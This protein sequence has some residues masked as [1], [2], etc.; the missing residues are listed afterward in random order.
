[1]TA[2]DPVRAIADAVLYEGYILWPYRRSAMKNQRRWTFGGVYPRAHSATHPDDPWTMRTECLLE[3][4]P[5][6]TVEIRVRFL[7]VVARRV[8]RATGDGLALVDELTVGSERHV[9]WEEAVEREI[10]VGPAAVGSVAA[11]GR[12][13]AIDVRDGSEREDLCAPDST[14]A[15]ALIRS[16]HALAGAVEVSAE[17]LD[18]ALW[19]VSVTIANTT[20][21][22]RDDREQALERTFCSTHTVLRAGGGGAFVSLT[23]PP[24]AL[25]AHADACENTG[26]WPVLVGE[27]GATGTLLSSPI[28]LED[29]PR[30]APESP[31]DLCDGGEIDQLL[32]LNILSLTD[33]EKAEM[34]AT[35][36]RGREILERAEALTP[37]EIM[38]LHGTIRDWQVLR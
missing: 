27:P 4:G 12:R 21:W 1:V 37:E 35:D 28:I 23:D 32:I 20:P 3:G 25:R 13:A 2:A 38:R 10:A 26:T 19:R 16:W 5:D 15:G 18:A 22:D 14:R 6:A 33:E 9:T 17:R 11:C 8:A 24:D 29:H 31:G 30:I 34:R 36:P 7:H